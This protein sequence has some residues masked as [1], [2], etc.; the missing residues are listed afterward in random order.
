ML[1]QI[2]DS[3]AAKPTDVVVVDD[4][5][6][7]ILLGV[8][9]CWCEEGLEIANEVKIKRVLFVKVFEF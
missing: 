9:G 3:V 5:G 4:A 2:G 6:F 7:C 1:G 8:V